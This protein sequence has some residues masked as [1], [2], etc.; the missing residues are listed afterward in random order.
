MK[1]P[2]LVSVLKK[3][4][5]TT[6]LALVAITVFLIPRAARA[7]IASGMVGWYKF[8]ECS[9]GSGVS[10]QTFTVADQDGNGNGSVSYAGNTYNNSQVTYKAWAYKV[11]PDGTRVYSAHGARF[12]S[13]SDDSGVSFKP[14]ITW[15]P[16]ASADGYVIQG[17]AQPYVSVDDQDGNGSISVATGDGYFYSGYT[18]MTYKVWAYKTAGDGTKVYSADGAQ[19]ADD[20]NDYHAFGGQSFESSLSWDPVSG[21]DGYV[22]ESDIYESFS[23]QELSAS[24]WQDVGNVTSFVDNGL[25]NRDSFAPSTVSPYLSTVGAYS[26]QDIGGISSF[27]D[28]GLTNTGAFTPSVVSPYTYVGSGASFTVLDSS[29]NGNNGTAHSYPLW[30]NNGEIGCA[31]DFNG[32][33]RIALPA[34][35]SGSV[36]RTVSAWI[37]PTSASA[38]QAVY[39]SGSES[40][41]SMFTLYFNDNGNHNIY[42]AFNNNDF[43][44]NA[45]TVPL[46]QWSLVT[47]AYSGGAAST[48]TV[49]IYINGVSQSLSSGGSGGTPNTADANYGIGYDA[50]WNGNGR[51]FMGDIDDVRVYSRAL[52]QSDATE[53]YN[54]TN[55]GQNNGNQ[56]PGNQNSGPTPLSGWAWSSNVGWLSF[57]ST[58]SGTGP[59]G[60]GVSSVAYGVTISTSTAQ[61]CTPAAAC[62]D[63]YAW[64]PNIGWVSFHPADITAAPSCGS[65]AKADLTTGAVTGFA[66]AYSGIGATNGWDGCIKLSDSNLSASV[67]CASGGQC[68]PS[69]DTSTITIGG[70]SYLKGGVTFQTQTLSPGVTQGI[71]DGFSWESTAIGWLNFGSGFG[72]SYGGVTCPGCGGG[73]NINVSS[74]Q[75]SPNSLQN[76]GGSVSLTA[77]ITGVPD[78]TY[79]YQWFDGIGGKSVQFSLSSGNPTVSNSNILSYGANDSTSDV[80]RNPGINIIDS[81]GKTVASSGLNQCGSVDIAGTNSTSN[82]KLMIGSS[83]TVLP[84][85]YFDSG[86]SSIT[87][88]KGQKFNLGW[89]VNLT[90]DYAGLCISQVDKGS[91][92]IWSNPNNLTSLNNLQDGSITGITASTLGS[93]KFTIQCT[94]G[95]NNL[96]QSSSVNLTVTSSS[97]G[98]I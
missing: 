27:S 45:N 83:N 13:V 21:A 52:S 11:A 15:D 85:G 30:A 20:S 93:Y 34:G 2:S 74:C 63:G 58:D 78:N 50:P 87:V 88:K 54:D 57:N 35:V 64:S 44:T 80:R 49:K 5:L 24:S 33:D 23:P 10:S 70:K 37:Y 16:V 51:Y 18:G 12:A 29:G 71:F 1:S 39:S 90:S 9:S 98:E 96:P 62:F 40:V 55:S 94:S 43:W 95:I 53:L 6:L 76:G 86:H 73:G 91:W 68:F 69:P 17:Y 22:I 19:F 25:A 77:T 32:N 47:A 61:G 72:G 3:A 31:I 66:R 26:W 97:E 14:E 38:S 65:A 79:K 56:N 82:L 89:N 75:V 84:S 48:A 8:D 81:S 60:S 41:N 92:P 28:Y 42:L 36:P 4:S 46:N 7:D 67:P 59:G